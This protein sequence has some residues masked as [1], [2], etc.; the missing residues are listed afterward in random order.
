[1][2][3]LRFKEPQHREY[4]VP[5]NLKIK[6]YDVPLGIGLIFLVL[7]FSALVNFAT[8]EVATISGV[9]FT[10]GLFIAFTISE[11]S[12]PKLLGGAGA[13]PEHHEHLEQFNQG[14]AE[15]LTGD[16]L[17]LVKPYRKLVAIRSPY[18]L[19]MLE[20]C[21]AETDPDTT[22]V[23][24]MTAH[25]V[26][27]MVSG[28][29]APPAITEADRA[30]LTAV[31]NLAEHAGKPVKPLIVPT[32]NP[33]YALTRT[34]HTVGA[35]ELIMGLSNKYDPDVQLD[36]VALY[37]L[38]ICGDNE[39]PLTVRVLGQGRDVRLDIAGGSQIPRLGERDA[40]AAKTLAELRASWR[41]V[42][43][44]LV[45]YDGSSLSADFLDTVL[46]FLDPGVSVTL[47]DVDEN[48]AAAAATGEAQASERTREIVT[49]GVARAREL[50]RVVDE[51]TVQ[52]EPGAMIV[53]I[54]MDGKYD[55]IFMS[56]RGEY[57]ALD[58]MVLATNTRYVLQHAPCRVVLG[59][60]PK[61]AL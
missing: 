47:I 44:I 38:N 21:L 57:R 1:M 35:Q 5:L 31:V 17:D 6:G 27:A 61:S 10:V 26:P 14:T 20:K 25:V 11:R 24:V 50:G 54:A 56:L 59:F 16:S 39:L 22:E 34:A 15:E 60:A 43:K 13:H 18:N 29:D 23:V 7:F 52:G 48:G 30:L 45:A 53:K 3:V 4:E 55:A 58:T 41:G 49:A 36:Q 2:L 19:S 32:N 28:T 51:R 40:A 9:I 8:K 37:W 33:M 42:E 46:S 12:R